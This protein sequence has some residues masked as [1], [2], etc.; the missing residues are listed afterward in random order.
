MTSMSS[1]RLI[2]EHFVFTTRKQFKSKVE[3][4]RFAGNFLVSSTSDVSQFSRVGDK[5][6]LTAATLDN[7]S[8]DLDPNDHKE[9][10]LFQKSGIISSLVHGNGYWLSGAVLGTREEEMP[11]L[12]CELE[13]NEARAAQFMDS[14][15]TTLRGIGSI[16]RMVHREGD[17]GLNIY[18]K[19]R[20]EEYTVFGDEIIFVK[21]NLRDGLL[22]S[23]L[24]VNLKVGQRGDFGGVLAGWSRR[25]GCLYAELRAAI[26]ERDA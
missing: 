18:V 10:R 24:K 6:L 25:D 17:G 4:L 1:R 20:V 15:G 12:D 13:G 5:E 3:S 16:A 22:D 21:Y 11:F 14:R 7:G 23:N 8:L 2:D 26:I 9:V 19:H